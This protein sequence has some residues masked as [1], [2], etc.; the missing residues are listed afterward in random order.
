MYKYIRIIFLL[1]V[2]TTTI[3]AFKS[4]SQNGIISEDLRHALNTQEA[5]L[6]TII[7]H[8][9]KNR[10]I[11][12]HNVVSYYIENYGILF[13]VQRFPTSEIDLFDQFGE[14]AAQ[15]RTKYAWSEEKNAI[16][17]YEVKHSKKDSVQVIKLVD[18]YLQ[19]LRVAIFEFFADYISKVNWLTE[20]EKVCIHLDIK[21]NRKIP[22]E[23][24][25]TMIEKFVPVSL[26]ASIKVADLKD[27]QMG[28]LT[29][30]QLDRKIKFDKI[31][32][33]PQSY[34]Y[35]ILGDVIVS[36]VKSIKSGNVRPFTI[37]TTSF[38]IADLGVIYF[39]VTQ[40]HSTGYSNNIINF[41]E[42]LLGDRSEK[43]TYG[44]RQDKF[45]SLLKEFRHRLAKSVGQ[46]AHKLDNLNEN[47]WIVLLVNIGGNYD[48][49]KSRFVIKIQKKHVN[50]YAENNIS[51][52]EFEEHVEFYDEEFYQK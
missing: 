33:D 51:F 36:T 18:E 20:N 32:V 10:I 22:K 40:H 19:D 1:L 45:S 50:D 6:E 39:L 30:E 42:Q 4:G 31:L 17:K 26:Q 7:K 5:I 37:Y 43:E 38:N 14:H 44:D 25:R 9:D 41:F 11:A 21:I 52:E 49:F 8:Y 34:N 35:K 3:L 29:I 2:L 47:Q 15:G 23:F 12:H 28:N 24:D 27:F 48:S 13:E 16:I 46:Y